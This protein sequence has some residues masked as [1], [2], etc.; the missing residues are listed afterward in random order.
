MRVVRALLRLAWISDLIWGLSDNSLLRKNI[1]FISIPSDISS[2]LPVF[3]NFS[4]MS[5]CISYLSLENL[6]VL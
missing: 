4:L 2:S 5:E 3:S 6:F 1:T